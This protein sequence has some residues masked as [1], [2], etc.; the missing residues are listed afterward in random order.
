[1]NIR[2][3]HLLILPFIGALLLS[4]VAKA[5]EVDQNSLSKHLKEYQAIQRLESTFKQTKSFKD[6]KLKL[7]SEGQFTLDRIHKKVI[8]HIKK[9]AD[10]KVTMTDDFITTKEEGR[11]DEQTLKLSEL[12]NGRLA[13]S[14]GMLVSWLE[15]DASKLIRQYSVFELA[16]RKFRFVPKDK[17]LS[18][19]EALEMQ[20]NGKGLVEHVEIS[21]KS[22]DHMSIDFQN[23]QIQRSVTQ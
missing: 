7:K 9:P 1:M 22:G 13:Q 11:K 10:L 6:L 20:L 8:W 18:P 4:G 5:A 2:R 14:M 16:D 21:E 23:N 3:F 17:G 15:M 19:F 12:G